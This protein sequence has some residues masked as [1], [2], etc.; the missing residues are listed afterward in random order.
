MAQRKSWFQLVVRVL[1]HRPGGDPDTWRQ[2]LKLGA[3][4]AQKKG[5]LLCNIFVADVTDCTQP[6]PAWIELPWNK[7][8]SALVERTQL[9]MAHDLES[10]LD[11]SRVGLCDL[12]APK[13]TGGTAP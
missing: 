10:A 9:G 6:V 3:A 11:D 2:V 4:A 8:C 5:C 7:R 13:R 12:A 1:Y